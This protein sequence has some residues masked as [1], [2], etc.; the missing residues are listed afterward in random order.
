MEG[1]HDKQN[2]AVR[3]NVKGAWETQMDVLIPFWNSDVSTLRS[4]E[5]DRLRLWSV[6]Y[7][8]NIK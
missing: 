5:W 7:S 4:K 2:Y 1:G 3:K 6:I 8:Q